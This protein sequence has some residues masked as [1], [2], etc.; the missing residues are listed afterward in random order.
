MMISL[1]FSKIAKAMNRWKLLLSQSVHNDSHSRRISDHS[2]S[3]LYHT[4]SIR[5][6]KKKLVESADCKWRYSAGSISWTRWSRVSNW[7]RMPDWSRRKFRSW[8]SG[9]RWFR[10]IDVGAGEGAY[11]SF[12]ELYETPEC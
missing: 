4:R 10:M 3:R 8:V 2:N 5:K 12:H 1:C 9:E 7:A 11:H 6:K